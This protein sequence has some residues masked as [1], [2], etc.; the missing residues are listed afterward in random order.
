M[1]WNNAHKIVKLSNN[2]AICWDKA[3]KNL[4]K[5]NK[6]YA[7]NNYLIYDPIQVTNVSLH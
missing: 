7:D 3:K 1:N 6:S 4:K 5:N 2:N